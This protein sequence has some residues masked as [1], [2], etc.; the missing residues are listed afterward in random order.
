MGVASSKMR[1]AVND[2]MEERG[3][4]T[5]K[6][7]EFGKSAAANEIAINFD[8]NGGKIETE[9]LREGKVPEE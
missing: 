3:K 2:F 4:N 6:E 5:L 9:W 8:K 7:M 1:G